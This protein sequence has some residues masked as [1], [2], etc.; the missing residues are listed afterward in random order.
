MHNYLYQITNLINNKI[1][2]GVHKTDDIDDGYMGSG[3]V[4]KYAIEKYGIENFRKDILENFDTYENALAKEAEIVTDEFLQRDDV[5][6]LRRGGTGGFDYINKNG[7]SG[8]AAHGKLGQIATRKG[9]ADPS[10]K[11][12]VYGKVADKLRNQHAAGTRTHTYFGNAEWGVRALAESKTE[13]SIQKRKNTYKDIH[14]QQGLSNS[15]YGKFWITDGTDNKKIKK[16]D[17]IPEGWKKG[18]IMRD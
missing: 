15:Q 8:A 11:K 4:I 3:K 13:K 9:L 1:Y 5:Y 6:N 12:Q 17:P 2:I 16:D 14:H 7:L 10:K 18:R